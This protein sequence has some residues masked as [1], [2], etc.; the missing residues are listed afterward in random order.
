MGD[1]ENKGLEPGPDLESQ[2]VSDGS[3]MDSLRQQHRELA[4][5]Q[6]LYLSIPGYHGQLY[7]KYRLLDVRHD[8]RAIGQRAQKQFPGNIQDQI[9]Y[10]N[11]DAMIQGCE[12]LFYQTDEGEYKSIAEALDPDAT[13]PITYSDARLIEFFAWDATE[14]TSARAA[15]QR[16][17][18]NDAALLDHARMLSNWMRDTS[19]D[20][21]E[22]F[23]ESL[24]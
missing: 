22:D 19:K 12:G 6:E 9:F 23:L 14:V 7:A 2:P 5:V 20:V 15:T 4:D 21:N 16:L 17:F 3:I 10:S 13:E 8:L 11:V 1:L 18:N 24:T